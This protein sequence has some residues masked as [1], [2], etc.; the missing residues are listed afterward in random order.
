V[1]LLLDTHILLWAALQPDRLSVTA[2]ELLEDPDNMLAFSAVNVLE[3]AIKKGLNREDFIVD[4]HLLRRRLLGNGY[5]E[6]PVTGSHAAAVARL[7]SVH[8]DPFD[9]L[10]LAQAVVEGVTFVTADTM[11]ARYPAPVRLV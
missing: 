6:L 4:P 7:P 9:R 10:L 1:R 2:T 8:K 11:L 3:V 5:T